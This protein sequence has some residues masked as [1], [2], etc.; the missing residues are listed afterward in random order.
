MS[1]NRF[2]Q[3]RKLAEDDDSL[4]TEVVQLPF[5]LQS[6]GTVFAV[7]I[8][9]GER[10]LL[11]STHLEN[12]VEMN[13]ELIEMAAITDGD[14]IRYQKSDFVFELGNGE[15]RPENFPTGLEL[16]GETMLLVNHRFNNFL[17]V[18]N[19]GGFLLDSG[20]ANQDLELAG[21]GWNT[22]KA[23]QEKLADL[24]SK[25][26]SL[27]DLPELTVENDD[28]NQVLNRSLE[29][30]SE[31]SDFEGVEFELDEID[32]RVCFEFDR[33]QMSKAIDGLLDLAT[34]ASF[35]ENRLIQIQISMHGTFVHLGIGYQGTGISIQPENSR[36]IRTQA[37]ETTGGVE[38]NLSR[39]LVRAHGG[40]LVLTQ[41]TEHHR[42]INIYLP[43]NASE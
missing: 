7:L 25:V 6:E 11:I 24:L 42:R 21:R 12:S 15:G 32:R 23:R 17:Q 28:L 39:S 26:V 20:I 22:V 36:N 31:K 34:K 1:I 9:V 38:F 13:G 35:H 10:Y 41:S 14:R 16:V 3:F 43:I 5:E 30:W 18:I 2:P 40:D 27:K 8:R 37:N 4:I 19:G 33:L 29:T